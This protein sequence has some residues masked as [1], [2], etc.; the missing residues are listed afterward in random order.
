M[1]PE[2]EARALVLEAR[3]AKRESSRQR[4][5]A[6]EKMERARLLCESWGIKFEIV[7]AET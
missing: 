3:E 7:K 1:S 6:R 5:I 4:E 2:E